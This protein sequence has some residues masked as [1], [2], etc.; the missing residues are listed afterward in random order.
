MTCPSFSINPDEVVGLLCNTAISIL[1]PAAAA[2]EDWLG[3]PKP[4]WSFRG[5]T[6]IV[7]VITALVC[8]L[9]FSNRVLCHGHGLRP[10]ELLQM[11]AKELLDLHDD[12][13]VDQTKEDGHN[14]A[15]K[16]RPLSNSKAKCQT[17]LKRDGNGRNDLYDTPCGFI[18]V[19]LKSSNEMVEAKKRHQQC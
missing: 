19:R 9:F 3:L 7:K 17:Y 11:L 12:L 8:L 1:L 10:V 14:H 4:F 5:T 16:R 18:I 6:Y 2:P 13:I 15:L